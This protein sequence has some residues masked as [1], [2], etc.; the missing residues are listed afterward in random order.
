VLDGL[1]HL[2]VVRPATEVARDV[3]D[4]LVIAFLVYRS[5]LVLK[6]TRAMQMGLGVVVFGAL[7]IVARYAQLT[8]V[9]SLLSWL[10]SSALLI[11]VVVFQNDIRRALIR[12]GAKAWLSRGRDAQERVLEEVVAAATELAR[13]RMGAIICLERDA[14]VLE[15]V[16]SD[17]V[18]LNCEVSREL[19]VSLFIPEAVNKLHDGAVLIRDLRIACAGVFLPMPEATR[20]ADS[21]LGSRHRAAIGITEETDAVVIVVSEERG[22]ITLCFPNGM[23]QNVDGA[24]LK[25]ALLGLFGK[26]APSETTVT[27]RPLAD[28]EAPHAQSRSGMHLA[29]ERSG[30][31]S[32][33]QDGERTLEPRLPAPARTILPAPR[34]VDVLVPASRSLELFDENEG[35]LSRLSLSRPM[36][37]TELRLPIDD[38]DTSDDSPEPA[39]S[40]LGRPYAEP[41]VSEEP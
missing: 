7:Y 18:D 10:A 9:T 11:L 40:T 21:S 4:I 27:E 8:T 24:S 12:L 23:V 22:T 6:G 29:V 15:F 16:K 19:L 26:R 17:G 34:R 1:N 5:L 30:P 33:A 31:R 20:V 25:Q 37:P 2:F 13:H 28:R 39:P 41:S 35:P 32:T 14:N 36:E 3:V 38:R